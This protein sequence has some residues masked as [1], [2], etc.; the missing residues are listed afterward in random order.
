MPGGV[1]D[2]RHGHDQAEIKGDKTHP[3]DS[4]D[5]HA[6]SSIGPGFSRTVRTLVTMAVMTSSLRW[7]ASIGME[8]A[9]IEKAKKANKPPTPTPT[10]RN[11]RLDGLRKVLMIR[12]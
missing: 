1:P 5:Q 4:C 9:L 6:Q 10:I 7:S 3:R 2:Q 12:S 11:G 8:M